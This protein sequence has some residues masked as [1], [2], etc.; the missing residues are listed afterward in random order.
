MIKDLRQAQTI[1]DTEQDNTQDIF[2][3]VSIILDAFGCLA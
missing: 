2:G 3:D 1:Q